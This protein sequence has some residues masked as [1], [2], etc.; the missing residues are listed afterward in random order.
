MRNLLNP[1]WLLI[2]NTLPIVLLVVLLTGEFHV[3]KSLLSEDSLAHWQLFGGILAELA[4]VNV[5]YAV[6]LIIKKKAVSVW[7]AIFGLVAYIAY[8]YFYFYHI[9]D[10][11]PSSIP[12]WMVSGIIEIYPC[13]FLMPMLAYSLFALVVRLTA[14]PSEQK[15]WVSFLITILIPVGVYLF[16]LIITPLWRFS[17]Y[18]SEHIFIITFI[19]AT[20][21]FLFFLVRSI[22]ILMA[23]KASFWQKYQ[24]LWKIPVTILFPIA[25][26]FLNNGWFMRYFGGASGVFGDF[27]S[28]W[29][30]VLA[31]ITGV[32]LCLPSPKKKDHRLELYLARCITFTYTFYFFV[33]FL[34][35][36][37]LSIPAIL[38]VGV[39]FLMLTPLVLFLIHTNELY[40]DFIYLTQF[41]SRKLLIL[42]ACTSF[43]IIPVFMAISFVHDRKVLDES[44]EY[45]YK[46]DYVKTYKV[47]KKAI[48]KTL[49]V[50][51]NQKGGRGFFLFFNFTPYISS[52]YNWLVLDNLTL[53]DKKLNAMRY[54]FEG[55]DLLYTNEEEKMQSDEGV[56]IT[57]WKV[58]SEYDDMQQAWK[59]W[60]HLEITAR[61]KQW[62]GSEFATA[63]NL[64]EG[65]FI[66]DYYLYVEGRKEMGILS[67]KKSAMWVYSQIKDEKKDPGILYYLSGNRVGF[68]VFPFAENEVR[69][70]GIE[71]IHKEPGMLVLD[72]IPML[73][74]NLET[75]TNVSTTPSDAFVQ[76]IS[77]EEK[78]NLRKVTRK[79]HFHFL[80]DVSA[81]EKE[82][83][84][85]WAE[86]IE[87]LKNEYPALAKEAKIS[88]V[89]SYVRTF[90]ISDNWQDAYKK[91]S[92]D[93]GFYA[94]RGMKTA[95]FQAWQEDAYPVIVMLTDHPRSCLLDV[96]YADFKF[97]YP[98]SDYFYVMGRNGSIK[99]HSLRYKPEMPL[100]IKPDFS[101]IDVLEYKYSGGSTYVRNN[102][103][104]EIILKE[105]KFTIPAENIQKKNWNTALLLRG[106]WL[107]QQMYPGRPDKDWLELINQSFESGILT[108]VTSYIVVE[109]EAQKAAL[110]RKQKEVLSS[111]RSFDVGE[112]SSSQRMS[113]PG[114]TVL[115]VLSG[116]I[117][118]FNYRRKKSTVR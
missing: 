73:L 69:K 99:V 74:G 107:S 39:G 4:L 111:D 82:A 86:Y 22:Y 96:N 5:A 28:F 25:G 118:F 14:S 18:G 19:G 16:G 52:Y 79:S 43:L 109:N 30:P 21:V 110:L 34:P 66:S 7:Y 6:F 2:V 41:F 13:T 81:H 95:L 35:Y 67:E 55:K 27:T 92:F 59:S 93:G 61:N 32:L 37:P 51:E 40:K 105:G 29:F 45:V 26:L 77:S 115:L 58:E 97:I 106:K 10:I 64:P 3:I 116:I 8:L 49:N 47:N 90:S 38:L 71:F 87:Q 1:R 94:D 103:K 36:L 72:S 23:K 31:L 114:M 33:V 70:T 76:Y 113:E 83:E 78:E 15:A 117:L 9:N 101:T 56:D 20:L 57:D 46:P 100:N 112:S 62:G 50:I 88:L 11:F 91:S 80:V 54:I 108:P 63:I 17:W 44:M 65:C 89:D 42:A 98:E 12:Q 102:G 75:Q 104:P 85:N 24:L 60:V 68:K 53:S 84:R 48:A